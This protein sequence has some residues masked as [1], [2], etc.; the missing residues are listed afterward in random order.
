MKS[1]GETAVLLRRAGRSWPEIA[2]VLGCDRERARVLALTVDPLIDNLPP[3]RSRYRPG[4]PSHER[5]RAEALAI[6][7]ELARVSGVLLRPRAS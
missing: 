2:R 6:A 3:P 4:T 5:L 7:N 1:A